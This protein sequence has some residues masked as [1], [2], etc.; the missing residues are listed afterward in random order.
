MNA[1]DIARVSRR[2]FVLVDTANL[3]LAALYV[4]TAAAN[5]ATA[6]CGGA[7]GLGLALALRNVRPR[8][9]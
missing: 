5:I 2:S 1:P 3:L 8:E 9:A 6:G 7:A 4:S